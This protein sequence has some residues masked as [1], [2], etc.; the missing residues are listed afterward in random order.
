[1]MIKIVKTQKNRIFPSVL[2]LLLMLC[3][4]TGC[5][6]NNYTEEEKRA[7]LLEARKVASS[8]LSDKYS[9][10][11]IRVMEPE[12]TVENGGYE[13]TEFASGSFVWQKQTY[14]FVVNIE[15]GEVYTSV[16]L[17]EIEERL[18][19]AVFLELGIDSE[20]LAVQR[21]SIYYLKGSEVLSMSRFLNVFPDG[22]SVE[23]LSEKILQDAE[24]YQLYMQFQYRGEGISQEMMEWESPF[25]TLQGVSVYH[26]AQEHALCD[27]EHSYSILPSLSEEILELNFGRD[28]A[29]YIRYQTLEQSGIRVTYKAYERRREQDVITE[30]VTN[31]EDIT[32]TMTDE[33]I[34]LDCAKDDYSMYLSTADQEIARKYLYVFLSSQVVANEETE[35]GMWYPFE[36]G[37]VYAKNRYMTVPYEIQ[38]HYYEG[39]VIYSSPQKK[40]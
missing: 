21:C 16:C 7:F 28:T 32:L 20:E 34:R 2:I 18:K 24:S 35:K 26:V 10:A 36:D 15:T 4:L 17:D 1:M 14:S 38:P 12:T 11:E 3:T 40:R 39:N 23:E 22:E 8:Y 33:Y 6:P 13:L 37:Y 31:E 5:I 19:A 30:S 9:G 25:P 27:E 29:S